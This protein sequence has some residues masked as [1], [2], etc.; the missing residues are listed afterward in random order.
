MNIRVILTTAAAVAALGTA[1]P[2]WAGLSPFN[3][4]HI[5]HA[6]GSIE[7]VAI[8]CRVGVDYRGEVFQ[9][10]RAVNKRGETVETWMNDF[11]YGPFTSRDAVHIL[12]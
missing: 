10:C 9:S 7:E 3:Y 12:P 1:S 4:E 6:D 2:T 8:E 5:S 11:Y